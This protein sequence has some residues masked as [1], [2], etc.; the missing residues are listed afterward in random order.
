MVLLTGQLRR[1]H[2]PLIALI[3]V[4][5]GTACGRSNF[6]N[7]SATVPPTEGIEV[8]NSKSGNQTGATTEKPGASSPGGKGGGETVP[9][10]PQKATFAYGP[11]MTPND[12]LFVIDNSVSMKPFLTLVQS[13]FESLGAASWFGDTRIGVMT[14]MPGDPGDL[15]KTHPDVRSYT[16]IE[17]EPGF[18]S[19]VSAPAFRTY[20]TKGGKADQYPLPLCESEWFKPA[21]VNSA[22]QRCLTVGLQ[23]P[24]HGVSCE[25]GIT[26][27]SQIHDKRGKVFRDGAFAQIIFVSDAQDPGCESSALLNARPSA[28]ALQEKIFNKNQLSGLRFHGVLTIPGGGTTGELTNGDFGFPYN[29]LVTS[30]G[31]TLLDITSSSDYS[32]FAQ[33][34]ARSQLPEPLFPLPYKASKILSVRVAGQAIDLQRTTLSADG[35]SVR[36]TRLQPT[37]DVTIEINFLP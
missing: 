34:V 10:G 33:A 14:T 11:R 17:F 8:D 30:T 15:G 4:A 18:L 28:A 21:D 1:A 3:V 5:A 26:A 29:Q 2:G 35:R 36:I 27:L 32:A 25:A 9:S 19:L 37:A 16:G 31:G 24:L 12:V 20:Q 22:G 13:G 6:R 23:S 7:S